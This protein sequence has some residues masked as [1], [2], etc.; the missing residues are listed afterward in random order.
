LTTPQ[1]L[2]K[3]N[4]VIGNKLSPSKK[5]DK[6]TVPVFAFLTLVVTLVLSVFMVQK[7]A[8]LATKAANTN[9]I[10]RDIHSKSPNGIGLDVNAPNYTYNPAIMVYPTDSQGNVCV[11]APFASTNEGNPDICTRWIIPSTGLRHKI[12]LVVTKKHLDLWHGQP[13]KMVVSNGTV[14]VKY[15][16]PAKEDCEGFLSD[17]TDFSLKTPT[18]YEVFFYPKTTDKP[19]T[20]QMFPGQSENIVPIPAPSIE[21]LDL[22]MII[23]ATPNI[24]VSATAKLITPNKEQLI[25]N[26]KYTKLTTRRISL[27]NTSAK[28]NYWVDARIDAWYS[29]HGY[30]Y[31]EYRDAW[32]Y[33][34]NPSSY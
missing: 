15:S 5:L 34:P 33:N 28:Y 7:E 32:I 31:H 8:R 27:I 16:D 13:Y 23:S 4:L 21:E 29:Y 14:V 12:T 6:L 19:M 20:I 11:G 3:L 17:V 18:A 24:E 10:E 1:T 26:Q 2:F 9:T 22:L 30:H 25:L